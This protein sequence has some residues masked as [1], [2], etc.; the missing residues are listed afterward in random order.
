MLGRWA[1]V[2]ARS[3]CVTARRGPVTGATKGLPQLFLNPQ[4]TSITDLHPRPLPPSWHKDTHRSNARGR[5]TTRPMRK[6]PT[7]LSKSRFFA[8][9]L[10]RFFFLSL[11]DD[12]LFFHYFNKAAKVL[13]GQMPSSE[14]RNTTNSTL[15][16]SVA[17]APASSTENYPSAPP[18]S[19]R[20][21]FA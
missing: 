7:S 18:H 12:L 14:S 4:S 5:M 2:H 20:C 8:Y 21:T 1:F 10:A 11:R 6:G 3:Q 9:W 17:Q 15:A 13:L 16:N 19:G